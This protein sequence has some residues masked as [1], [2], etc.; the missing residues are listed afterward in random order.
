MG[1]IILLATIVT[2]S[3]LYLEVQKLFSWLERNKEDRCLK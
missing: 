1:F 2:L 3:Y